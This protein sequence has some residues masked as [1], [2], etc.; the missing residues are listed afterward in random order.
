MNTSRVSLQQQE[1][2][3]RAAGGC[4]E[5]CRTG[6]RCL[7]AQEREPRALRD[8]STQENQ[9]LRTGML[10]VRVDMCGHSAGSRGSI[11]SACPFPDSNVYLQ[12]KKQAKHSG[13]NKGREVMLCQT[14][15]PSVK[16]HPCEAQLAVTNH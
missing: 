10:L 3:C 1:V 14:V 5:H 8:S 13:P 11:L 6:C 7:A 2:L 12:P 4:R 16:Y 15:R 9:G